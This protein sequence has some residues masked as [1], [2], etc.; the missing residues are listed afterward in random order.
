MATGPVLERNEFFIGGQWRKPCGDGRIE[1]VSP[2]TEEVIGSTPE[3]DADDVDAAVTA[4]RRAF[5]SG[6]WRTLSAADRAAVIRRALEILSAKA[7]EI[8]ALVTSEMG[9]PVAIAE[10]LIP[11]ALWT[12]GYFVGV[13]EQE[14]L[15]DVR[16]GINTAVVFREPVGVVASIAPWNGPFNLAVAKLVPALMAGCSAVFKPAPETPLDV[17][18]FVEALA[19]AGLPAGV[20]NLIVGGRETG[21]ALVAHPGVDKVSF[22]GSTAAGRQIGAV[23]GETF[24]RMQLEL[25]GKSAAIILD[26]ADI[27]TAMQ[28]LALGSFFNT[29]QVCAAYS[30]VLAP[31]SRYGEIVDA[32]CATAQSFK[33]GDPFDR[34]TTLGPLVAERQRARVEKY[35]ALGQEEGAKIAS[36]GGR[37][38]HLPRGWFV[39]PTVFVDVDNSMRIAQEEI[40]GPVVSV[41]RHDGVEDAIR[42]ANDSDYGLHG[43]VFTQDDDAALE[44][45]RQ[46][47]TGTFSVNAFVYNVEAPFGGVKCSG[48]GRD[49]GREAVESYFELKTVNIPAS[50][51]ERFVPSGTPAPDVAV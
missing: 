34:Q 20:L 50:M 32:L 17:Y 18:Y 47:K 27:P 43:A 9:V 24:K 15:H 25:G 38:S 8:A 28:G 19:E 12:G 3:A 1:V 44:V 42:I 29:G 33:L 40:F 2:A 45:A 39:E 36:G 14:P 26:D 22:T 4:A 46:V 10:Q 49:T 13:A 48:V 37:P 6:E 23:C 35:I 7:N 51:T 5:D 30:R 31:R 16:Q 21:A 41:I 11:G